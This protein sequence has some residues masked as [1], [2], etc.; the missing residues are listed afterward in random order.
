M[1]SA[2]EDVLRRLKEWKEC[3]LT[4]EIRPKSKHAY[5]KDFLNLG[6][7]HCNHC[8]RPSTIVRDWDYNNVRCPGC[9]QPKISVVK[10]WM[11]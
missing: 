5:M 3:K 6:P 10:Q 7:I 4:H 9:G 11:T 1:E 2:E 8:D